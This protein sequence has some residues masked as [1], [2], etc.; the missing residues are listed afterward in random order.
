[1]HA[2]ALS[3]R[4]YAWPSAH[5]C[6]APAPGAAPGVPQMRHCSRQNATRIPGEHGAGDGQHTVTAMCTGALGDWIETAHDVPGGQAEEGQHAERRVC[7]QQGE[8]KML[9][10]Q[11]LNLVAKLISGTKGGGGSLT[12]ACLYG[13]ITLRPPPLGAAPLPTPYAPLWV[14]TAG[15]RA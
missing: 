3:L 9:S 1:M 11:D 4:S 14:A 15:R 8:P 2:L 5:T 6:S 7:H 12:C 10:V 13:V